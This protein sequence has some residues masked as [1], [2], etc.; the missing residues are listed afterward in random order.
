M[1]KPVMFEYMSDNFL[2]ERTRL[3]FSPS[4]KNKTMVNWTVHSRRKSI[5]FKV[6]TNLP[7]YIHKN[8]EL[9]FFSSNRKLKTKIVYARANLSILQ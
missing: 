3:E 8:S 5:L 6:N 1:Q 4:E 2:L 9:I 7:I